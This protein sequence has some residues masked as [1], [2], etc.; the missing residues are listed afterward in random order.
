MPV[1]CATSENDSPECRDHDA[2]RLNPVTLRFTGVCAHLEEAY[3]K[4]YLSQSLRPMRIALLLASALYAVFGALDAILIPEKLHVTWTIRFAVVCPAGLLLLLLS[5][6]E[7]A[8]RYIQPLLAGLIVL[9]GAGVV[10]MMLVADPPANHVYYVGLILIFMFGYTFVRAQFVWA[11]VAAWIVVL[12]YEI[13][14]LGAGGPSPPVWISNNFFFISANLVG[15]AAGYSIETSTRRDFFMHCLLAQ[16]QEKVRE[17]NLKLEERVKERT[18]DLVRSNHELAVEMRERKLAEAERMRLA[19]QLKQAEKMEAVG[20]MAAGVAHDLNNIL[21]GLVSYPDLLL[22][23]IPADSP[24]GEKIL[25]IK[26]S[27]EKAA[28][29]VQ[30]LLTMARRGTD[31]QKVMQPNALIEEYFA[32]P[33]FKALRQRFPKVSFRTDLDEALLNVYASPVHLSKSLMNLIS[34]AAEAHLVPGEVSVTT[35]NRSVDQALDAY[36]TIPPGDYITIQVRD[37]G[38]G[39]DPSELDRIFEPFFTK[40]RMGNSGT[41]LGLSVVWGTMKDCGGY[42]D[43]SSREGK[44]TTITLYLPVTRKDPTQQERLSIEDY[45]GSERVLVVDDLAEQRKIAKGLLSKLGYSV[46][47]VASGEA[48]LDYLDRESA[49]ILVLDMIMEP[50]MDGCDTYRQILARVP[51]QKAI[52]ASGYAESERVREAQR[53]GAGAYVQKPYT[54]EKL[55]TALRRELD[56]R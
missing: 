54:L 43:V 27:G 53:L 23:D 30:D 4:H 41:G 8:Q 24:L 45:C 37:T 22:M 19:D 34:N 38:V 56:R 48:A 28:A 32:S 26:Q 11:S 51:G 29:M 3:Q 52:I 33:E 6:L 5:Y 20:A 1:I 47:T 18:A 49:D 44:G 14:V 10:A 21:S 31:N 35:R 42:I 16:E 36:E 12:L 17:A 25:T 15:M 39:I 7:P 13:A 55:A 2:M 46:A 9:G 40:K 50:G